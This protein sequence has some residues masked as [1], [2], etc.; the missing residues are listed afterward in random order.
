MARAYNRLRS[1]FPT[2]HFSTVP[3]LVS[4]LYLPS[5]IGSGTPHPVLASCPVTGPGRLAWLMA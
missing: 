3:V 1:E 4:A 2:G 5:R